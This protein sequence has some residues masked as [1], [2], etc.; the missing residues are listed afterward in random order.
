VLFR[1]AGRP[2]QGAQLIMTSLTRTLILIT[3]L[4]LC[5][6]SGAAQTVP[7]TLTIQGDHF[8]V[9]GQ[10]RFLIFISYF[11]A[12]RRANAG[13]AAA[14]ADDLAFFKTRV[15]GIRI[16][17]NWWNCTVP[18]G[19]GARGSAANDSLFDSTGTIRDADHW[20]DAWTTNPWDRFII[21]L[22]AAR[23][24]GLLVDVTFTIET[25]AGSPSFAQYQLGISRVVSRLTNEHPDLSGIVLFDAANELNN[26]LPAPNYMHAAALVATIRTLN[27]DA[28]ATAS[29]TG[30][31]RALTAGQAGANAGAHHFSMAAFH[32]PRGGTWYQE[33]TISTIVNSIRKS[34]GRTTIPVVLDEPTKWQQDQDVGHYA[35]AVCAAHRAGA[36]LWTFHTESGHELS[37]QSMVQRMSA[38]EKQAVSALRAQLNAM[39][40][41][42]RC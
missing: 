7:R 27:P 39:P 10:A 30:V 36:A 35:A 41:V 14:L 24:A 17:V 12:M 34:L 22:T 29:Q 40:A 20:S 3:A 1:S 8:A 28:I 16:M 25:I 2:K 32:E 15:D 9:N 23:H 38:K 6:H 31:S 21:V 11:D 37:H 33:N 19:C 42:S 13:G 18:G 5:G 4:E 26:N